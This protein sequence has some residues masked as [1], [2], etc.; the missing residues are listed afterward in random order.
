MDTQRKLRPRKNTT[1]FSETSLFETGGIDGTQTPAPLSP[2]SKKIRNDDIQ[3]RGRYKM[4][5][6]EMRKEL[7]D[8]VVMRGLSTRQVQYS[9]RLSKS[10][11]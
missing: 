7:V 10:I 6:D 9:F 1:S 2:K 5:T 8:M 11:T 3:K 4:I